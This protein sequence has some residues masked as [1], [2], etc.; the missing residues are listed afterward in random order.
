MFVFET[1]TV[2]PWEQTN[3]D[4]TETMGPIVL[5]VYMCIPEVK[6]KNASWIGDKDNEG[7]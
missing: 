4:I 1:Y 7:K 5:T 6:W 3:I 2:E